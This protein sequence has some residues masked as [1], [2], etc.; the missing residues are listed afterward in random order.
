MI[1]IRRQPV[2]LAIN[3]AFFSSNYKSLGD[4]SVDNTIAYSARHALANFPMKN[5]DGSWLYSTPYLDYKIANGRHILLNEGTH[6]NVD[7]SNAFSNTTRLVI[8]PFKT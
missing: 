6:R 5:P 3:S 1:G 2:S 8:T 7:R 4:G